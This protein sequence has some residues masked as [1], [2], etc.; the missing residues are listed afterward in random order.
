MLKSASF[1]LFLTFLAWNLRTGYSFGF[2][3]GEARELNFTESE[4]QQLNAIRDSYDSDQ[5]AT[6]KSEKL[7]S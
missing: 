6:E 7:V 4:I 5:P 1:I 2:R 3:D